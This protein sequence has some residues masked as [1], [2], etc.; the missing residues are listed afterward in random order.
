MKRRVLFTLGY[1]GATVP[2][3]LR[4]LRTAGVEVLADVR[5]VAHSRRQGFAKTALRL[6][7][8]EAGVRYWHIPALGNPKP[9]REA[10]WSGDTARFRSIFRA[11]LRTAA[12]AEA[13][14]AL[15][16]E[17]AESSVCLL[18]LEADPSQCHR[19]MVASA[20]AAAHG[21]EVR[22]LSVSAADAW[23]AAAA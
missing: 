4:A 6:H 1:E 10:A 13:L 3:F 5:A 16:A 19:A 12:A 23:V 15:A 8:S 20:L 9:G 11:H 14:E 2:D 21:F 22:H 7:L 17:A 18:C